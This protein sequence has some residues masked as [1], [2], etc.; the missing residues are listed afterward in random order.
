MELGF[1]PGLSD[2]RFRLGLQKQSIPYPE[3][4]YYAS[5]SVLSSIQRGEIGEKPRDEIIDEYLEITFLGSLLQYLLVQSVYFH[6]SHLFLIESLPL[7][8][9]LVLLC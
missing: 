3:P 2:S 7:L 5:C 4:Q 9:H 6:S 1:L 8:H